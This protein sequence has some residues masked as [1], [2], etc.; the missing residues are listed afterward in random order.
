MLLLLRGLGGVRGGEELGVWPRGRSARRGEGCGKA[1]AGGRRTSAGLMSSSCRACAAV[2]GANSAASAGGS[3]GPSPRR[4]E[5]DRLRARARACTGA[6]TAAAPATAAAAARGTM[7]GLMPAGC[8]GECGPGL[9]AAVSG[10]PDV[11]S[12][13]VGGMNE[14]E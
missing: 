6:G 1:A 10:K 7:R 13:W 14:A 2:F 3:G 9:L 12:D 4:L 8:G 5:L 11:R